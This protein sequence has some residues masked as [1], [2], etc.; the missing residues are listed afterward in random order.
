MEIILYKIKNEKLE[1]KNINLNKN[2]IKIITF[3]IL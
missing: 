3:L 2:K 1:S